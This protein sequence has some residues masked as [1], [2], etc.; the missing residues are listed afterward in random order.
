MNTYTK[1]EIDTQLTDYMTASALSETL[2]N[3]YAS[4]TF[5]VDNFYDKTYLDNQFSLKADASNTVT[6]DCLTTNYNNSV[7]LTTV[8]YNKT[9]ITSMLSGGSTDLSN[10]Y[11]KTEVDAIVANINFS[12][13]HYTKTEVDDIDNELSVLIFE[14]LY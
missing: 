12:N 7:D 2:T 14:Y 6:T 13:N 9:E 4:I 10:Y 3:N 5:I 1:S 11:I 8:F